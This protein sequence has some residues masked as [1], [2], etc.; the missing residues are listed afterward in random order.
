M[1]AIGRGLMANPRLLLVDEISLGLAPVVVKSLYRVL[2]AITGEGT[3][4]VVVD[5]DVSQIM[6][7]AHRVYCL[8]KGGVSLEG[9]PADLTRAH[10]AA[11]YFGG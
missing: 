5:Q 8:R 9:R 2:R 4:T 7:L 6:E 11:A 1:L 10:I 3:T